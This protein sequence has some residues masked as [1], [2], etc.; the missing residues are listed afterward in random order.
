VE[1]LSV[2]VEHA[3]RREAG[4]LAA[5]LTRTFGARNLDLVEDS[6]QEAFVQ[7]LRAWGLSGPP[8]SPR[9]WLL[10]AARNRLLDAL[11]HREVARRKAGLLTVKE[12]VPASVSLHP[13]GGIE[14]E[15]DQLRLLF[16]LCQPAVAPEDRVA[17]VLK[18]LGGFGAREI[19]RAYM[20]KEATVAQRLVRAKQRIRSHP[21]PFEV[22]AGPGLAAGLASVLEALYA[23]FGEGYAATE[24][25]LLVREDICSEALRLSRLVVAHPRL[26]SPEAH[27]LAA[28]LHLQGARN[29]ERLDGEGNLLLL[30]EQDRSAWD[31][32]RLAAGF[33]HLER[34]AGGDRLSI[35]HLEAGIAAAHAGAPSFE[36]TDWPYILS[37]YEELARWKPTP[38]VATNRAVALAMTAGPRAGLDSLAAL[39]GSPE[40][41]GYYPY[42]VARGELAERAGETALARASFEEA[43]AARSPEPVRRRLRARLHALAEPSS[44]L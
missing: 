43:L 31:R 1:D 35:Y 44:R 4:R 17:L 3:F 26:V 19:A 2:S 9:A 21:P 6:I 28:L 36:A 30:A 22:P 38:V 27:A 16:L 42:L 13:A 23:M 18:L 29:P 12:V 39:S 41:A 32:Q 15:D 8:A 40:V 20:A 5:T 7:A 24:G 11:R 10:A 33:A 37:L 25:D 34:A 14:D